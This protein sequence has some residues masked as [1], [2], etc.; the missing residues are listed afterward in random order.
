MTWKPA[1]WLALAVFATALF[2]LVFDRGGAGRVPE[3][4]AQR[5]LVSMPKQQIARIEIQAPAYRAECVLKQGIWVLAGGRETRADGGR[6]RRILEAASVTREREVITPDVQE[7]RGLTIASFGLD[8]P[9]WTFTFSGNGVQER[10]MIGDDAPLGDGVYARTQDSPDVVE[11]GSELRDAVPE[12]LDGLRDTALFPPWVR[13][14]HRIEIKQARGFV[15]V[16]FRAGEWRLQQPKEARAEGV[17]VENLLRAMEEARIQAFHVSDTAD[18]ALA[19]GLTAE[20]ASLQMTVAADGDAETVTVSFGKTVPGRQNLM[21]GQVSDMATIFT[22]STGVVEALSVR[23]DDMV[24]RRICDADP[25][26]VSSLLV[27]RDDR[28]VA[29]TMGPEGWML[30]EP[31]RHRA[32]TLAVSSLVRGL[33]SLQRQGI[34]ELPATNALPPQFQQGF[35]KIALAGKALPAADTNSPAPPPPAWT[36]RISTNVLRQTVRAIREEDLWISEIRYPDLKPLLTREVAGESLDIVD[37]RRYMSTQILDLAS[38]SIRRLTLQSGGKEQTVTRDPE[39]KWT[40]DSPPG[41]AVSADQVAA[42]LTTLG[43]LKAARIK[44]VGIPDPA[45]Y[46]L[47]PSA[48]RLTIGLTGT[49]GIQKILLIG[50]PDGAGGVYV[51]VQGQDVVFTVAAATGEVLSRNLVTAPPP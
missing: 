11:A 33:C 18:E 41:A 38:A 50:G 7:K 39:D 45:A 34:P 30:V 3:P 21:Y 32:D 8:R 26:S 22:V 15:K 2:I 20:E 44:A 12:T 13:R 16:A 49:A 24:D 43:G 36:Y 42:L 1:G 29:L 17:K 48:K 25:A 27:Q 19:C 23:A 31:L 14:A 9:R 40:A 10:V 37:P 4:M 35:V 47:G 6:I 28:R 51:T 5:L 46:G